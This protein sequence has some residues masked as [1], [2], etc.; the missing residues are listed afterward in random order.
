MLSADGRYV[1]FYSFATN[2]VGGEANGTI[3]DIF[4]KGPTDRRR[5]RGSVS[6]AT[7]TQGNGDSFN[8]VLSADGRYVAFS[9]QSSNLVP[10]DTNGSGGC[11]RAGSS[12]A[13]VR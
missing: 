5:R 6:P 9:S 11:V 1:A 10:G 13:T 8:P 2:L 12:D 4:V 3:G 7:C